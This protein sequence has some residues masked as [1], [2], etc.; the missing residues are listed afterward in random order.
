[1][2]WHGDSR[3]LL[4]TRPTSGFAA[5]GEAVLLSCR[6][7]RCISTAT[8]ITGLTGE[9]AAAAAAGSDSFPLWG[10]A[11]P[12]WA[13]RAC[14][15]WARWACSSMPRSSF[16][17]ATR[18]A[19]SRSWA[20]SWA[21]TPWSTSSASSSSFRRRASRTMSCSSSCLFSSCSLAFSP[22]R[23]LPSS[24]SID[25]LESGPVKDSTPLDLRPTLDTDGRVH[26]AAPF[27]SLFFFPSISSRA[28]LR[29][30][31]LSSK[32]SCSLSRRSWSAFSC[33]CSSCSALSF[34][35]SCCRRS[36]HSLESSS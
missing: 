24:E 23:R 6:S 15:T 31:S 36:S 3:S 14:S 7:N 32:E 19:F 20:C 16:C 29:D 11:A 25:S 5:P 22:C 27:L 12:R 34:R 13:R 17:L 4:P 26:L 9:A 18:L 2:E 33:S 1:M 10:G 28:C 8:L 35:A 30:R 21:L